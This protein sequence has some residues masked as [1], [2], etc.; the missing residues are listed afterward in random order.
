MSIGQVLTMQ[1]FFAINAI[2]PISIMPE[3]LQGIAKANPLTYIVDGLRTL[4]LVNPPKVG[5]LFVDF[6]VLVCV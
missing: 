1:L 4:M 5:S 3:W 2:Y 6:I